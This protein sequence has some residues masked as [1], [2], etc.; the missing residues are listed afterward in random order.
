M[1]VEF[2]CAICKKPVA[3]NHR[4]V[5]CDI[6]NF[7][8]HIK[9]NNTTRSQYEN[10]MT[11]NENR[12]GCRLCM[13]T[14]IPFQD[15]SNINLRATIEGKDFD[16]NRSST[17]EADRLEFFNNIQANLEHH[18]EDFEIDTD[19]CPYASVNDLNALN[20]QNLTTS[21]FHLN[22]NSLSIHIDEL[23]DFLNS[24]DIKFDIIGISETGLQSSYS[25]NVDIF[26]YK[27]EDTYT[28]ISKGGTRIYI[29]EKLSY[30]PRF[31]LNMYESGGLESLFIEITNT[32][33]RN[34]IVGC[35]YKHPD[36]DEGKFNVMYSKLLDTISSENK[37]VIIMGDFNLNLLNAEYAEHV[38]AFLNHNLSNGL[39][40]FITRPTRVTPT[41][42]TLIDNIFCN[43][44]DEHYFAANLINDISDHLPQVVL[45]G[46]KCDKRDS[47]PKVFQDFS[48]FNSENFLLDFL[49]INWNELFLHK[50]INQKTSIL[51][52]TVNKL[53]NENVPTKIQKSN[54][55]NSSLNPWI[56]AGIRKSIAHKNKLHKKF[57]KARTEAEKIQ[58]HNL[59]KNYRNW[60]VKIQ[61]ASKAN[62]YKT[63]FDDNKRNLNKLWSGIRN[64]INGGK[65][66]NNFPKVLSEGDSMISSEVEIVNSFN[67]FFGSIA[68]KTKAKIA[69]ASTIYSNY[70]QN[71]IEDTIFLEPTD[72]AE[73]LKTISKLD[74]KKAVGPHSIPTKILKLIGPS[75]SKILSEIFNECLSNGIFPDCLKKATVIP[76]HKGDSKL[77]ASNYRPVSLLSNIGKLLELLIHS[78]IQKFLDSKNA[79]FQNQFGF[80]KGHST[81]HAIISLCEMIRN[82]LDN[83]G[84]S[85][86]IFVDLKK[87]FDT[88]EHSILLNK[89][90]HY[91]IRGIANKLL[92]S[93][94][95]KRSQCV[96]NGNLCSEF[97]DILHG[98]PQGSVLGPLLFLV[99][100]N[101]L[102]SAIKYSTAI[103]FAD[104]T[105]L[106]CNGQ[107]LKS[108][109]KSINE[110][111]KLL[112]HWLRANKI[113]LN[114][115]KTEIIIFRKKNK[116]ITKKLNFRL[117]GQKITPSI[118]V[119]YLGVI[120]DQHL[121][122]NN[123]LS[124]L[125]SKLS[126][127]IGM[128]SKL[129][130]YVDSQTLRALYFS[131]FDSYLNYSIQSWG[132][133]SQD[134]LH[135]IT[136]L[137]NKALRMI[138]F[139]DFR[140]SAKPLYLSSRIL[141]LQ[142]K[143]KL[144]NCL[145]AFDHANNTLPLFFKNFF[146]KAGA[147]GYVTRAS[148]HK[149]AVVR[150]LT[151]PY[152]TFS[153]KSLVI[154]HWNETIDHL[155]IDLNKVSRY[156]FKR[157][158]KAYLFGQFA[159]S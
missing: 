66:S 10:L 93:Y 9:C 39:K 45:L 74:T 80:R 154:S 81:N 43:Y 3:R 26:S 79:I 87:A 101:D 50:D 37:E 78:R 64:I 118:K 89:L 135:R 24:C 148:A 12:W 159:E 97:V 27:Y 112:V 145:F 57:L 107:S 20:C 22:I 110:D 140:A 38:E 106:I 32:G 86:G 60:L 158:L 133:V 21:I 98:V 150:T 17:F 121:D 44:S 11:D 119:K 95:S 155:N 129:R 23:R 105:S 72:E 70:L 136:V 63:F 146:A 131:L 123:H 149:L 124:N 25:S 5:Q 69:P 157:H 55:A 83:D 94:L 127:S 147:H 73:I 128:L 115:A 71:R 117:S 29:S 153:T 143:I 30:L 62:Y 53:I 102:H 52:D 28:E 35:V 75:I 16:T 92:K 152:G 138:N 109:N 61:R 120:L 134:V 111:M 18:L 84:F 14:S 7:W 67:N 90:E 13:T 130:H 151:V 139:A 91:G 76:L 56:T 122:W 116:I 46:T 144:S 156:A 88:V 36:F 114:A 19:I 41:S 59:F 54:R 6:C 68:T 47:R 8:V 125:I 34:I 104:D 65:K 49:S 141:P 137:Q 82:S 48:R 42:K 15:L 99:Y 108:L 58:K 103:H 142:Y 33:A 4:A 2:P 132:Q 77:I 85:V 51:I 113:A 1:P 96:R 126:R 40:P 31:E 100:I